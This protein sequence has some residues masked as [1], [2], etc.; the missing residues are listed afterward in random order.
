MPSCWSARIQVDQV[1][2][3]RVLP[4]GYIAHSVLLACLASSAGAQHAG[5]SVSPSA[6]STAPSRTH[7]MVQAIP[8]VTRADPSAGA[9][10]VSQ[11]A[12][13]QL[14][15]MLRS[16]F[17]SGHGDVVAALDGEGLTIPNGELNTGGYGEGFVDRRHPHTYIHEL[18]LVGR[19]AAGPLSWS[20]AAGRG[21]APFG[22][23]DPMMRPI[24]KFPINHH[25][26]QILE[27]AT[28]I[29]AVRARR[30]IVEG[31][32]FGGAEPT[33]P[34]SLP[35]MNRFGDSWAARATVLP[36][37]GVELQ[38]SHARAASPEEVSGI[39][40][41]QRKQSYSA[42]TI[43]ADGGRYLLVEWAKTVERVAVRRTD[44]FAYESA[45]AEGA[46]R[47]RAF[48]IALRLEQSE[49]PEEDRLAE[50]FRTP[51]PGIDLSINGIT[52]WRTA[53]LHLA[54]PALIHDSFSGIPFVEATLLSAQARSP[55]S[56][57]TPQRLYGTSRL[58][59]LT[60]GI[61]LGL[62]DAHARMGRYGVADVNGP[63]IGSMS[64]GSLTHRH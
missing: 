5:H 30:L 52:R 28:V 19:W 3:M 41:D 11:V 2:R 48:G 15:A 22:T 13:S 37:E 62:G 60:A 44:V 64:A 18:M 1:I 31:G 36:L 35:V 8:L 59:M 43:S 26:A 14:V 34:S 53:T 21:F 55:Q 7:L 57:F 25:L 61:R 20:T 38:A 47:L 40:L 4:S 42:R 32:T 49:R 50:P 58:S 6:D 17:A 29:G 56:L 45:L 51:R 16:S 23:D 27:R 63:A 9:A 24:V 39:G 10:P 54:A 12:V 33:Q 46:L